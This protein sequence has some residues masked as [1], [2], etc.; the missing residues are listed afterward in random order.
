MPDTKTGLEPFAPITKDE[1]IATEEVATWSKSIED[2]PHKGMHK[3]PFVKL[4]DISLKKVAVDVIPSGFKKLDEAFFIKRGRHQLITVAGDTSHGKSAL[5]MQIA[6]TVSLKAPVLVFSLE[7]HESDI[8]TRLL[9][10]IIN[11][12][13]TKILNG[14]VPDKVLYS[15]EAQIEK[16]ELYI[17][18][19]SG[20]TVD[21]IESA[22][23][24]QYNLGIQPSLIVVDYL[25][26]LPNPP[27][28]S[29]R[30]EGITSI[31]RRLKSL[32]YKLRCPVMIGSQVTKE[33]ER[34]GKATK[35]A[36][37]QADYKPMNAY[38]A[39]SGSIAKDSDV[40]LFVVRPEQY[41]DSSPGEAR[42]HCT[43]NRGGGKTFETTWTWHGDKCYFQEEMF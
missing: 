3:S 30:N 36:S 38:L 11:Q 28:V 39:D 10:P 29:N 4:S 27:G 32:S 31:M 40:I 5:M 7:M 1:A 41:D 26:L 22:C 21:A 19:D 13:L 43:K 8:R 18:T 24:Y 37:G 12:P 2:T 25:Q 23:L 34:N 14:Q 9:A 20:S 16:S 33:M 6:Y 42:I 35:M 17:S 15:A